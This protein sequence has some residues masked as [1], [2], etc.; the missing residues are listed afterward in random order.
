VSE[1]LP[2]KA[3]VFFSIGGPLPCLARF[4]LCVAGILVDALE[5]VRSLIERDDDGEDF[6][7]LSIAGGV[8]FCRRVV[9]LLRHESPEVVTAAL[10][11]VS[12]LLESGELT[13][14]ALINEGMMRGL[15][16]VIARESLDHKREAIR[17]LSR[18][19]RTQDAI[20]VL[21]DTD[22]LLERVTHCLK[23]DNVL[24]IRTLATVALARMCALATPE[25]MLCIVL[26]V[27]AE[28]QRALFHLM[29]DPAFSAASASCAQDALSDIHQLPIQYAEE[30]LVITGKRLDEAFPLLQKFSGSIV[31]F[32]GELKASNRAPVPAHRRLLL[33][34]LKS[35]EW[36][37]EAT[38]EPCASVEER[39]E[40]MNKRLAPLRGDAW[41]RRN[42]LAFA[43]GAL[44]KGRGYRWKQAEREAAN[45]E[46]SPEKQERE[47]S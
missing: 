39:R 2:T 18:A 32:V 22:R 13:T 42:H 19:S 21:I 37:A 31:D 38:I 3:L 43:H 26:V 28:P 8:G 34:L 9:T 10:R 6:D 23:D 4:L 14:Q 27:R 36:P 47:Q 40:C 30:L 29:T 25:Q 44:R 11:V 15:S 46:G 1:L 41:K 7:G 17:L 45:N 16:H 35:P 33:G 12:I 5:G 24:A 20:Q